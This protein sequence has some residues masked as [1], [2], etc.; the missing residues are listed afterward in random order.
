[1]FCKYMCI[2]INRRRLLHSSEGMLG[3]KMQKEYAHARF[4]GSLHE[5]VVNLFRNLKA[6][7]DD[8]CQEA[9]ATN[10]RLLPEVRI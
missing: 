4:L 9:P 10:H 8:S 7:L 1:M 5:L 3:N 6:E 2:I